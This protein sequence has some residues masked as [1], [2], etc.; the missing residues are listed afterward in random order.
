[1]WKMVFH[2]KNGKFPQ[3]NVQRGIFFQK[4]LQWNSFFWGFITCGNLRRP[5]PIKSKLS[6]FSEITHHGIR[7]TKKSRGILTLTLTLTLT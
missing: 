4:N 1:M 7:T 6:L 2:M 3:I 5:P